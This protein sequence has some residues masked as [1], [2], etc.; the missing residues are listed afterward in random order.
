MRSCIKY[1]TTNVTY[2]CVHISR[3]TKK[4]SYRRNTTNIQ[5]SH[6]I[7]FLVSDLALSVMGVLRILAASSLVNTALCDKSSYLIS[8]FF[9]NSS[10]VLK[11]VSIQIPNTLKKTKIISK[12]R[13]NMCQDCHQST[14]RFSPHAKIVPVP[15]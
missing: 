6:L 9:N 7:N 15:I 14:D 8:L 3:N 4:H 11:T 5:S 13:S 12:F 1:N 10:I 2:A